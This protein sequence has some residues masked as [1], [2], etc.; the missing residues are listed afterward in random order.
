MSQ[1]SGY[2]LRLMRDGVQTFMDSRT[3]IQ[4]LE[5]AATHEL[6]PFGATGDTSPQYHRPDK[7]WESIGDEPGH[8][9]L[10][11]HDLIHGF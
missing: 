9:C 4:T 6:D 5:R 11:I 2:F 8:Y 1:S 7:L 3:R 10:V